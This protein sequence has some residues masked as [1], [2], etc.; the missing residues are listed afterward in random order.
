MCTQARRP[1]PS[2]ST[3]IAS[4]K[5]RA[6]GGSIVIASS[7][8]RSSRRPSSSRLL[9]RAAGLAQRR[10]RPSR[11]QPAL[12]QQ[13]AQD[14]P[15]VVGRA[16]PLDDPGA[17]ARVLDDDELARLD[18]QTGAAPERELLAL[19]EERLRD[20]EAPPALDRA[21]DE[22]R[23]A[24]LVVH[25]GILRATDDGRHE[26]TRLHRDVRMHTA[27]MQAA[28]VRREVLGDGELHGAAAGHRHDGLDGGLAE[29]ARTDDR[30]P[31]V[32]AQSRGDDLGGAR[33]GAVDDDHERSA[34]QA[35]S[36]RPRRSFRACARRS[37]RGSGLARG[38]RRPSRSASE[39]RPPGLPRRSSTTTGAWRA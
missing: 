36:A 39:I 10:L 13:R 18:G 3:L 20:E 9:G 37:T 6:V 21:G 1:S 4:S 25:R 8:S 26:E 23:P 24:F 14:V 16:Q 30:G 19:V 12:E 7:S 35:P 22:P 17:A 34:R 15:D 11:C 27:A 29:R 31:L 5:S 32:L 38:R 33:G 28:A 2:G